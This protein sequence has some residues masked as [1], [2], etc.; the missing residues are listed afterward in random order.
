M[1]L[2]LAE[3]DARDFKRVREAL[4]RAG[5][6]PPRQGYTGNVVNLL[7]EI[8]DKAA[9]ARLLDCPIRLIGPVNR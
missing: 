4:E 2:S 3:Q 6:W 5:L 1:N 7:E 9:A 8:I